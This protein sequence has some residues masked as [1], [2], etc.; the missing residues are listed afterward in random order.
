MAIFTNA[1]SIRRQKIRKLQNET[2]TETCLSKFESN[3]YRTA[4]RWV[5]KA[6][7]HSVQH[8]PTLCI[9]TTAIAVTLKIWMT[10]TD[11]LWHRHH[12]SVRCYNL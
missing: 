2:R 4:R 3:Q 5:T 6:V 10:T 1:I 9:W 7:R 11:K 8:T 12:F